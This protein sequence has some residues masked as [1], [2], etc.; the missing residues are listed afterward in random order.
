[1]D[2][3]TF[4][5]GVLKAVA[6]PATLLGLTFWLRKPIRDLVP[7]L[8]KL[9]VKE[10]EVEFAREVVQLGAEVQ[11]DSAN[12]KT[13]ETPIPAT[14]GGPNEAPTS[15][16]PPL[17]S[18]EARPNREEE[19]LRLASLSP[20]ASIMEA[21]VELETAAAEM[22]ASFWMPGNR[23][24]IFRNSRR[25]GEY[26]LQCKVIDASQLAAFNKLKELRNKAVHAEELNLGVAETQIYVE[27]AFAL[28]KHIRAA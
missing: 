2:W 1:M 11:L 10:F 20:R 3:L 12:S 17:A 19:V 14:D 13:E 16:T 28:A 6:W 25:L 21:W 4:I 26:L 7:L 22:A 24:E 8:R 27:L 23:P 18:R 9:K 15:Q 5:V